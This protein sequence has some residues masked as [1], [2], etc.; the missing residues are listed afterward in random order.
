MKDEYI[1]G[2]IEQCA[3]YVETFA[4]NGN[5]VSAVI[6]LDR[7]HQLL[8]SMP[9]TERTQMESAAEIISGLEEM[10]SSD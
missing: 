3:R 8:H 10:M 9:K 2:N 7:A 5:R 6:Y 1:L 4:A